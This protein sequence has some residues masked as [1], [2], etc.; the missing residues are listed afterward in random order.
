MNSEE[1]IIQH[2]HVASKSGTIILK[3]PLL[4]ALFQDLFQNLVKAEEILPLTLLVWIK[5]LQW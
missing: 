2:W 3:W 5:L 4:Q 1:R